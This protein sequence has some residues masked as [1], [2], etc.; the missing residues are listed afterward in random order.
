MWQRRRGVSNSGSEKIGGER[1]NSVKNKRE[2][3]GDASAASAAKGSQRMAAA[4]IGGSIGGV[5]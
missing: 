5:W 3:S 4:G 1:N 2:K